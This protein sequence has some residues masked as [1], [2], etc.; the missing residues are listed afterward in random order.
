M[1][2]DGL[3]DWRIH[4]ATRLTQDAPSMYG[5]PIHKAG[6][7]IHV[8]T[9]TKDSKDRPVGFVTPNATAL[10][11]SVALKSAVEAKRLSTALIFEDVDTPKGKGKSVGYKDV[12]PLYDYFEQCMIAVTF[13]FQALETY[14]NQIIADNLKGTFDLERRKELRSFTSIEIEKEVSTEEK[15]ATVLPQ[16]LNLSSPKGHKVWEDFVK[17]KRARDSTTHFKSYDQFHARFEKEIIDRD[18]L[19]YQ[20]LNNDTTNFP[21][22]AIYMIKYF[23]S[24]GELPRWLL[25]LLEFTKEK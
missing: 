24:V 2:D 1:K 11:L 4:G 20:F 12:V 21:K 3:G 5:G 25:K 23:A 22:W 8:G 7:P 19:F 18:T 17:L 6:T 15:L 9:M 13:S 10:A 16:L 14:S